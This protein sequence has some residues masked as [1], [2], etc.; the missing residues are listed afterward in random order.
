MRLFAVLLLLPMI[1]AEQIRG[2]SWFGCETPLKEMICSWKH[3]HAYYIDKFKELGFNLIRFP[4]SYEYIENGDFSVMD[5][6]IQLA[7]LKNIQVIVDFHRV[8]NSWQGPDPFYTGKNVG[9]IIN[10]WFK[11]LW[12]YKNYDN[13]IAQNIWNE[14]QGKD[15]DFL[16]DYSAKIIDAVENEFGDRYKH[17]VTGT[18]WSGYLNGILEIDNRVHCG[19]C[20]ERIYFSTHQYPFSGCGCETDWEKSFGMI[21]PDRLVIGEWGWLP[22]QREWATR[23][24]AYLKKKGIRDTIWWSQSTSGDTIDL[25]ADD[26]ETI[27]WEDFEM[28][29]TQWV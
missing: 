21:P 19:N 15:M 22:H 29:K 12:R 27:N 10:M 14:Y 6:V 9:D 24:I 8:E 16:L 25:F 18:N 4:F 13:V 5:D 2:I 20:T 17:Y 11:V 7:Y 26:C 23:M 28:L 1:M 3:P